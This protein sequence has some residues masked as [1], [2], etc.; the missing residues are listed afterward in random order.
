MKY[1]NASDILPEELL[2]EIQKYA[3]GKLLYIPSGEGK[4]AWGETSGYRAQ[5]K[6]RNRMIRN[7]YAYGLT[8]SELADE[9]FLSL[10]SIKKIVYSKHNDTYLAYSPTLE[11]AVSYANAGMIEEWVQCYLLLTGEDALIVHDPIEGESLYFGVI[12]FPLRLIERE[13]F[14]IGEKL[15]G[16]IDYD[17]S[18]L[19]PLLIQYAAGKFYCTIQRELLALLKQ[20]KINA[21]PSIICLKENIEYKR[22]MKHFGNIFIFVDKV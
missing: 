7:K 8:V 11:S 13:E 18:A 12:K 5:L 2:K 21:F 3:A 9:Y 14:D 10:D 22:F 15:A 19:P 4:K 1:E 6:K 16:E 17:E 20:R